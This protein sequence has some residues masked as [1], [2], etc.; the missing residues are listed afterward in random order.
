MAQGDF[1]ITNISL[2]TATIISFTFNND[3]Q[4]AH[5][6]DLTNFGAGAAETAV[7]VTLP[8]PLSLQPLTDLDFNAQY[9]T[10]TYVNG[11]YTGGIV[12]NALRNGNPETLTATNTVEVYTVPPPPPPP[13]PNYFI[14][15]DPPGVTQVNE[16]STVNFRVST[17]GVATGTVLY[18][19][20][21]LQGGCTVADFADATLQ[22]TVTI[23]SVGQG[24]ISRPIATDAVDDPGENFY[25]A[26]RVIDYVGTITAYSPPVIILTPYVPPPPPPPDPGYVDPGGGDGGGVGTGCTTGQDASSTSCSAGGGGGDGGGDCFTPETL[27]LMANGISKKIVDVQIGDR[28]YNYN[29]TAINTVKF[30]ERVQDSRWEY[31]YSP[32]P[33]FEPF[34]TIHHPIY[35][36]GRLSSVYPNDCYDLYPWLGK[37]QAIDIAK[38]IPAKGQWVYNLWVD[39]DGT[40]T[41]N[42][43]GTTSIMG[44]GDFLRRSADQGF[45]TPE[46]VVE[47]MEFFTTRGKYIQYGGYLVNKILGAINK[48][49]VDRLFSWGLKQDTWIRFFVKLFAA[50]V[51]Y[52]AHPNR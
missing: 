13:D 35:I 37:T 42:G 4:I 44:S 29:R 10:T 21:V 8:T 30:I 24:T 38:I 18:W 45:L 11:F 52:I 34:A 32:E 23:D 31:L 14:D 3:P 16:G 46:Q 6:A 22:G 27:I 40:Y 26:L 25:L 47:I 15:T 1:T 49:L 39:G 50:T 36:N 33:G 2:T 19:T 5:S 48:P 7:T 17:L 12:I 28:V 41:A 51:G 43:Y 9:F 20:T